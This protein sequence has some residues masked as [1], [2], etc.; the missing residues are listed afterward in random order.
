VVVSLA[1]VDD[2]VT[3][4]VSDDGIG[5]SCTPSDPPGIGLA[6]VAVEV[7]HVGGTLGVVAN[8]EGGTTLRAWV[9]CL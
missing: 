1:V 5:G 6:S 4:A 7:A 3:L 9:P 2:G 8:E